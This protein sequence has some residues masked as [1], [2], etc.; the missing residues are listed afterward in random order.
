M[1]V[2]LANVLMMMAALNTFAANN[3][4]FSAKCSSGQTLYYTITNDT[5]PYTVAVVPPHGSFGVQSNSYNTPWYGFDK[6][7]GDLVIPETVTFNDI[8]YTVT[9]IGQEAFSACT[10]INNLSV[11]S[12]IQGVG[13]WAFSATFGSGVSTSII[14][15]DKNLNEYKNALYLGNTENPYVILV[16]ARNTEISTCV[17]NDGCK[18]ICENAFANCTKLQYR[19]YDNASYLGTP[20]NPFLC[21]VIA[22]TDVT[23]SKIHKDCKFI[24]GEHGGRKTGAGGFSNCYN[25]SSISFPE[26]IVSIGCSV[27]DHCWKLQFVSIPNTVT[28]IGGYAFSYAEEP[29]E[30]RESRRTILIPKSVTSVGRSTFNGNVDVY[31]EAESKP[32][33]WNEYCRGN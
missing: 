28:N 11:P 17:I 8:T 22:D 27:F 16:K 19:K 21:L 32:K 3:Y 1:K 5:E 23:S 29:E 12:T 13:Y 10:G 14:I 20:Q 15:K 9:Y 4:D 30:Y 33:N 7:T 2:L 25:L 24:A 6:P 18:C 31:C 26:G